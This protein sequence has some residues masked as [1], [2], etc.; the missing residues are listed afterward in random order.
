MAVSAWLQGHAGAVVFVPGEQGGQFLDLMH[1]KD[2]LYE[3]MGYTT[4]PVEL[5]GLL[6]CLEYVVLL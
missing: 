1:V 2:H 3:G 6:W 4:G 5:R